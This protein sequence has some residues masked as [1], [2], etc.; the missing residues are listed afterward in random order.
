MPLLNVADRM[1]SPEIDRL[2]LPFRERRAS[3]RRCIVMGCALAWTYFW[4]IHPNK[5]HYLA[6]QAQTAIVPAA[7]MFTAALAWALLVRRLQSQDRM[8]VEVTGTLMDFAGITVLMNLAW[9]LMFPFSG[10]LPLACVT[11][12]ARF[13]KRAA[14]LAVAAAVIAVAIAAPTGYWVSRPAVAILAIVLIAG[15]P[16]TFNRVLSGLTNISEQAILARDAQTRFLAM[17]SHELRTPLHTVIHAASLVDAYQD[18]AEQ[19]ALIKSISTNA[20][21]LLSRLTDALDVAASQSGQIL[22][23]SGPFDICTVMTTVQAVVTSLARAKDINLHLR[24]DSDCQTVLQGD[25]RRIEQIITNLAANAIKYTQN[26]GTVAVNASIAAFPG[27]AFQRDLMVTVSDTGIGIPDAEKARIFD[28]FHQV[29]SGDRRTHEGVGLG[30]H[31]VRIISDRLGATINVRDNPG[32][33]TL[34][35]WHLTLPIVIGEF[36][37]A[38]TNSTATLLAEHRLHTKELSCLVIDDNPSNRDIL[39]RLLTLGGHDVETAPNGEVGIARLEESSF[40]LTFLDLHMPGL[41]GLDVLKQLESRYRP[42]AMPRVV[43]LTAS[44]DVESKKQSMDLHA[45]GYLQK[46]LSITALLDTLSRVA[47]QVHGETDHIAAV[48]TQMPDNN[49]LVIMRTIAGAS[50]V[51]RYMHGC[52]QSLH[53]S[54]ATLK[55]IPANALPTAIAMQLH[56]LKNDL[57]SAGATPIPE[58]MRLWLSSTTPVS[59][60]QLQKGLPEISRYVEAT[61]QRLHQAPELAGAIQ[62]EES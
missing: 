6:M 44:T 39:R 5:D 24:Y 18:P 13:N 49:P 61:I 47:V 27:D 29:S 62:V 11:T 25:A 43:I 50:D 19:R 51:Q 17:M 36:A 58:S 46:P 40:D 16:L 14:H 30:L 8:W 42:E 55:Q 9:N 53:A 7:L 54:L 15:I 23:A 10:M 57:I 20:A 21:V 45:I 52:I 56:A 33:G 37:A 60:A 1:H 41:S 31:I 2:V 34:F 22:L 35:S 32:G 48:R 4:W 38:V 26:G 12:G 28:A 59:H 3:I